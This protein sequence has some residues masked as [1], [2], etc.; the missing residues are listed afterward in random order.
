MIATCGNEAVEHET[1]NDPFAGLSARRI[2]IVALLADG[3]ANKEIARRLVP[4]C[5]EGT[6]K[7]HLKIIF[8]HTRVANRAVL[9]GLWER[10]HGTQSR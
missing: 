4:P 3:L 6:V 9:A 10:H 7:N 5:A 8:V 1:M 2:A